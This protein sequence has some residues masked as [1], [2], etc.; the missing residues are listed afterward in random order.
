[1][2]ENVSDSFQTLSVISKHQ[3]KA[4]PSRKKKNIKE[5]EMY[6]YITILSCY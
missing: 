2:T 3:G 5:K 4:K 1:M 6:M